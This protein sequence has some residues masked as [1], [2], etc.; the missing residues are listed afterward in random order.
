MGVDLMLESKIISLSDTSY[1]LTFISQ[2]NGII[3]ETNSGKLFTELNN[4]IIFCL[5]ENGESP[6]KVNEKT[7]NS[8]IA[9]LKE[10]MEI[11]KKIGKLI[12]FFN[13]L[14]NDGCIFIFPINI[15]QDCFELL[16]ESLIYYNQSMDDKVVEERLLPFVDVMHE[17]ENYLDEISKDYNS[18]WIL[19]DTKKYL[20]EKDKSKRCCIYCGNKGEKNFIERA[21]AIPEVLGNEVIQN[22]ECDEC[23]S[24]FAKNI[25]ED[26]TN[27]LSFPR[28]I[29]GID[30][31][32]GK[33]TM[34]YNDAEIAAKYLD[35]SK[36]ELD[37]GRFNSVK[38]IAK[39]MPEYKGLL[40]LMK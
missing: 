20:G 2:K 11:N 28:V 27:F 14:H 13:H 9:I 4:R 21:H 18:F 37:W 31:K 1:I 8:V 5:S 10:Y 30:G 34:E 35:F 29:Y 6:I 25:E 24:Y 39:D 22:E 15:P 7:R 19:T 16:Q 36:T 40:F 12:H 38:E 32:S 17:V 26:F 33:P 23:N 3:F